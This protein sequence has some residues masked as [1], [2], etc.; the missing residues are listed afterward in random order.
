MTAQNKPLRLKYNAADFI[1][2][3][4]GFM[5]AMLKKFRDRF[6]EKTF[7]TDDNKLLLYLTDAENRMD[8]KVW[9]VMYS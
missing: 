8:K 7:T 6:G 4:W 2:F 9:G 3:F 1:R 5:Q